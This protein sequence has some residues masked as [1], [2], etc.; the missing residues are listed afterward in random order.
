MT[1]RVKVG[2]ES[3]EE[4]K[5]RNRKFQLVGKRVGMRREEG[6][7]RENLLNVTAPL[8]LPRGGHGGGGVEEQLQ[9]QWEDS[10][11]DISL[12]HSGVGGVIGTFS[13]CW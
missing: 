3:G 13:P 1:G 2:L 11:P 8:P 7:G 9:P 5:I 4:G 10:I 6:A 12:H